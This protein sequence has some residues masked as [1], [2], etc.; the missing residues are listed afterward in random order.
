MHKQNK[1][2]LLVGTTVKDL[3]NHV[4]RINMKL[5]F[6]NFRG[7]MHML[8]LMG[9]MH[10]MHCRHEVYLIFAKSADSGEMPHCAPFHPCLYYLQVYRMNRVQRCVYAFIIS[11]LS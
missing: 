8:I 7:Q 2:S 4:H 11:T 10:M 6:S 3:L 1:L 9:Q 5:P